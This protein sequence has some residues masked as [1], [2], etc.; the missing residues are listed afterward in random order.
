MK[1]KQLRV[2]VLNNGTFS[3][4]R[5]ERKKRFQE[6]KIEEFDSQRYFVDSLTGEFIGINEE[7]AECERI[8][9]CKTAQT[10]K[11]REHMQYLLKKP[12]NV[13]LFGTFTF[14]D[15]ALQLKPETRKKAITRLLGKIS[16]DYILNIDYGDKTDR[17]HYHAIIAMKYDKCHMYLQRNSKGQLHLKVKELDRYKYGIYGVEEIKRTETD[18]KKLAA[19][20]T[21]LT[22]HSV[23]VNQQYISVKKGSKYQQYKSLLERRAFIGA[24]RDYPHRSDRLNTINRLIE[25]NITEENKTL[26]KLYQ[27]FGTQFKV[28]Q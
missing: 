11:V 23:K 18:A 1:N 19:Y 16:E 24:T 3:R 26:D 22:L 21:K 4:H 17:E 8:R 27:V 10:K 9:N 25:N 7:F 20:E 15:K 14:T 28:V 12:N 13:L 5:L 2:E 6:G